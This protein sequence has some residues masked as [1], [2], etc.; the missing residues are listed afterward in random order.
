MLHFWNEY[1]VLL[2]GVVWKYHDCNC[3][4]AAGVFEGKTAEICVSGALG[5]GAFAVAGS[6]F[7]QQP[8]KPS[9]AVSFLFIRLV[10]G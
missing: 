8:S 5:S 2:Y 3:T 1:A 9:G 4:F 7:R 6:L 10:S